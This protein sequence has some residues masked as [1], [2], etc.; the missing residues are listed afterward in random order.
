[1]S[2][3][4][5]NVEELRKRYHK[6]EQIRSKIFDDLSMIEDDLKKLESSGVVSDEE[7]KALNAELA[8]LRTETENITAVCDYD[9]YAIDRYTSAAER[10]K[11][12][13][14]GIRL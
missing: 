5:V 6:G 7:L 12:M 11:D 10:I 9:R 2:R 3:M 1:M 14:E 4:R 13:T 8:V